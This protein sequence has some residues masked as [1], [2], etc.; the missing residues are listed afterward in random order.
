MKRSMV[1]GVDGTDDS[2]TALQRAAEL[3]H[4][5]NLS[6]IVV[7]IRHN[8]TWAGL[9]PLSAGYAAENLD[10]VEEEARQAAGEVLEQVDVDWEFVVRNGEPA[11]ELMAVAEERSAL[12]IVVGGRPHSAPAS[13]LL[14]SVATTLVHHFDGSVLVVRSKDDSEW[15]ASE[16][17]RDHWRRERAIDAI[18]GDAYSSS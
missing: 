14:G 10:E 13:A 3:S 16:H 11:H 6:L 8:S 18:Y 5:A 17:A 9:S 15:I 1:V 12:Y 4:A 7:H 2:I